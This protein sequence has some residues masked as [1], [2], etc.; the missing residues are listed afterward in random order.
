MSWWRE[1]LA[2]SAAAERRRLETQTP[3][4]VDRLTAWTCGTLVAL[5]FGYVIVR[6]VLG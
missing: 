6:A 3:E 1:F 5:L 2:W 4:D